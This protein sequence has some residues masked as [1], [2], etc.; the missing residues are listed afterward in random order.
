MARKPQAG[1]SRTIPASRVKEALGLFLEPVAKI[2]KNP[3]RLFDAP[4][5]AVEQVRRDAERAVEETFKRGG[6]QAFL[7]RLFDLLPEEAEQNIGRTAREGIER[8]R[9][10]LRGSLAGAAL[11]ALYEA[12]D[13]RGPVCPIMALLYDPLGDDAI[14]EFSVIGKFHAAGRRRGERRAGPLFEAVP[15]L[16]EKVYAKYLRSIWAMTYL[17]EGRWP[18]RPPASLGALVNQLSERLQSLPELIDRDAAHFRNA[19]QHQRAVYSPATRR[20]DLSDPKNHDKPSAADWHLNLSLEDFE[21]RLHQM[22][23]VASTLRTKLQALAMTDLFLRG[24]AFDA[25]PY[26][27]AALRGDQSATTLLTERNPEVA[28]QRLM[29]RGPLPANID[30][31]F[32]PT[33][34]KVSRSA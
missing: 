10:A 18:S 34:S 12:A 31:W 6:P 1:R 16:V 32:L 33:Q 2:R 7:E 25:L 20:V 11:V 23:E 28:I 9:A 24:G 13:A 21:G 8:D 22:W 17:A 4:R 15:A 29:L 26:I 14:H 30:P 27:R 3:R 19:V 5:S